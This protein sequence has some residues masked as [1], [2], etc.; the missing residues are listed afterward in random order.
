[1]AVSS[2]PSK[3]YVKESPASSNSKLKQSS[4][5]SFFKKKSS[6][7]GVPQ[8]SSPINSS[9]TRVNNDIGEVLKKDAGYDE[10]GFSDGKENQDPLSVIASDTTMVD[11]TPEKSQESRK[12]KLPEKEEAGKWEDNQQEDDQEDEE[13]EDEIVISSSR[14]GN[15]RRKINYSELSDDDDENV[16]SSSKKKRKAIEYED[17]DDEFIV[18]DDEVSEDDVVPADDV[19]NDLADDDDVVVPDA[20][21]DDFSDEDDYGEM[22]KIKKINDA[23]PKARNSSFNLSSK[24]NADSNYISS[25]PSTANNNKPKTAHAP[26]KTLSARQNFTKENEERYKWL[27]QIK[28]AEGRL[29][30]DPEY[31]PRTLYIPSSAWAKFTPFEKQYWEIKSKMWDCIVFFKKGKFFELYEKDADLAHNLFELKIAG[32]GRANMK[33]AGIPEMSFDYWASCF[34]NKGYKV[35]KVDQKE[36]ML[37]K[38]IRETKNNKKEASVITRE[39]SFVLTG[40][41]LT[42]E[43]MLTDDMA[44]YCLALKECDNNDGS[45]SFGVCF[46]DTATGS[47]KLTEFQDDPECN[48]LETLLAQVRPKEIIVE[49][50]HISSLALRTLKFNSTPGCI[51]NFLK[52]GEEFLDA[53]STF[54]NLTRGKYFEAKDLDD[55]SNYPSILVDYSENH[56][57]G[58]SAFGSLLWYLK[59][60]KLDHDIISTGNITKYDSIMNSNSLVLDGVTLQNLEIFCNSFDGSDKGTLIKILNR[61]ITPFGK[62]M[63]KTWVIHPLFQKQKIEERLDSVELLLNDGDLRHLFESKLSKI[64]DLERM[65]AR[66]HSGGLKIKDFVKVIEGYETIDTLINYLRTQYG[67][68]FEKVGGS[69]GKILKKFP[70]NLSECISK[71][72]DAFDRNEAINN[73]LLIPEPGVELSFDESNSHIEE[74]EKSLNKL[75]SQ[76]RREYKCQEMCFKDSGKEIFLIETPSKIANKIPSSWD[77]MGSTSKVKRYWSPEVKKL[78]RKLME[79][80]E[81]HKILMD[82]LQQKLYSRFY[83]DYKTWAAAFEHIANIDCVISLARASES[84]G[85]PACRPQ[86]VEN[87]GKGM[88]NFEELR[89]P[90]FIEGGASGTTDFIPNDVKLGGDFDSANLALLTGANAAG[91]STLLRMTCVAVLMAQIGCYVPCRSAQLTPIDKI[92]TR[93]GANDNIMQGKSTFYVE[94]SETKK[95]L[96]QSTPK[97]LIVLDELGRG[98]SLIFGKYKNL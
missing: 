1:M 25:S 61:C 98:G 91:K 28:D 4:L 72:S 71:W 35:A 82:T 88:I 57:V 37:A 42:D 24:F 43:N 16:P 65:L 39:L 69:I 8:S 41:T 6:P 92:M 34:I 36:S 94:L 19:A 30:S 17:S 67:D 26:S 80:R 79:A 9:P 29:E 50:G 3:R 95:I 51:W 20:H 84:I 12:Q 68:N 66:I 83:E 96:S 85:S 97:S 93:L 21:D 60:L 48:H 58:F 75:L 52:S 49:K 74:L 7:A 27:I 44:T 5:L 46:V 56:H 33:L 76:Y 63:F 18:A 14:R 54:E 78:A 47:I 10:S 38:E 86:F 22:E 73:G 32:G 13:D 81:L 64:P 90:C 89:H 53:D 55:L 15:A 62:R 11:V 23:K 45:K 31:D 2:T 87:D 40:G 59:S 77:Q 70:K